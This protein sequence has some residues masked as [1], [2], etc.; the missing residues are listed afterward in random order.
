[1]HTHTHT[2]THT[3]NVWMPVG[4]QG[5]NSVVISDPDAASTMLRAEGKYPSRLIE[6]NMMW[7][8]KKNNLPYAMFF[9]WASMLFSCGEVLLLVIL[10]NPTSII[11]SQV[12][13]KMSFDSCWADCKWCLLFSCFPVYMYCTQL[14]TVAAPI[15]LQVAD[16]M[17]LIRSPSDLIWYSISLS[18]SHI[19]IKRSV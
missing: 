16:W 3:H 11:T 14:T 7:I 10:Y 6:E 12:K 5:M 19:E 1:M 18:W 13:E 8:Y 15:I 2:H 4:M 9:S 17:H